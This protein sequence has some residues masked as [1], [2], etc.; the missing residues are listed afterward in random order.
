MVAAAVAEAV[1]YTNLRED[2]SFI[3]FYAGDKIMNKKTSQITAQRFLGMLVLFLITANCCNAAIQGVTGTTFN[4]SAKEGYISTPEG[5]SYLMWGYALDPNEMQYPG[6]T[7]IVN[8]G[9]TITVNLTN[10]LA[11]PVSIVFP[12]QSN[13][14]ATGGSPGLLTREANPGGGAVSYT[15]TAS[16]AGTYMYH[17]GTSPELQIEMGRSSS[18]FLHSLS[19]E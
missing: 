11:V 16:Q 4:F 8:Q 12:G 18:I 3:R 10:Q 9:D 17:S 15:F 2:K 5:G 14:V 7:L 1:T 6:P 13:V 19:Q